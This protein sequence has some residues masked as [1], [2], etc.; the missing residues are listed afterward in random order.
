MAVAVEMYL[1]AE[2]VAEAHDGCPL[3]IGGLE[4]RGDGDGAAW[5]AG[6][7]SDEAL[8]PGPCP[9]PWPL[10]SCGIVSHEVRGRARRYTGLWSQA[11][12][13]SSPAHEGCGEADQRSW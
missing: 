12:D 4:W 13:A 5:E 7:G 9:R 1:D 11:Q 10:V 2:G 8:L 6:Q 3:V